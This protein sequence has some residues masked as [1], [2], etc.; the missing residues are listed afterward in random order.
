MLCS[1][2]LLTGR[3]PPYSP[4][5]TFQGKSATTPAGPN[6][7]RSSTR[8]RARRGIGLGGWLSR[9]QIKVVLRRVVEICQPHCSNMK[10]VRE[11]AGDVQSTAIEHPAFCGNR[12]G[13]PLI[14]DFHKPHTAFSLSAHLSRHC[15][16]LCAPPIFRDCFFYGAGR[17]ESLP[18]AC[19]RSYF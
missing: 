19:D 3:Y 11:L 13:G 12:R 7:A 8:R 15:L 16:R 6:T 14:L 5:T 18:L 2:G 1:N 9:H 17:I 4:S 10:A